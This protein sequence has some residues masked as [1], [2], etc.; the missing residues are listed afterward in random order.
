MTVTYIS[1]LLNGVDLRFRQMSDPKIRL[2]LAGI[3]IPE[4]KKDFLNLTEIF[5]PNLLSFKEPKAAAYLEN[6]Q[7]VKL[8]KVAD[9]VLRDMKS[10]FTE[11]FPKE[12]CDYD[13]AVGVV[14]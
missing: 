5:L 6:Y 4:V 1:S 10:Y 13:I 3:I 9:A 8:Y 12:L 7:F 11:A 2:N 14:K